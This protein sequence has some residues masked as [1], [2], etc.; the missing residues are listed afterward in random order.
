MVIGMDTLVVTRVKPGHV[1]DTSE[2]P[3]TTV[4]TVNKKTTTFNT[5]MRHS[6]SIEVYNGTGHAVVGF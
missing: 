1:K 3:I 6:K 2:L 5:L 4:L